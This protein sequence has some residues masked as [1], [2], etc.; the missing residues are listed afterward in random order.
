MPQ[1]EI[2][3]LRR[4]R[5][6]GYWLLVRGLLGL[7][8][9]VPVRVGRGFCVGLALVGLRLRPTDRRMAEAN[10]AR[11]FPELDT[12]GREGLLR[13]SARYLGR[14]LFDTLAAPRL[15]RHGSFV[16][17][18]EGRPPVGDV[19]ADLAAGG[20]GVFILTGHLGCWEL[21]GGYLAGQ[22]RL[23]GFDG[24]AVVTSTVH[25]PAV[26][27]LL[28]DRRRAMGMK[29]LPREQGAG[30]LIR[31]LKTGGVVAVLQ[32]QFTTTRNRDLPFFGEPA[33]TPEGLGL[34]ARRY[35]VPVLPVAIAAAP[36]G[37]G[38]VVR[39]LPVVRWHE[40]DPSDDPV[41]RFLTGCNRQL[42]TFIRRN[43]A[44]W[45]WFHK[46]WRDGDPDEKPATFPREKM[47]VD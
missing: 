3:V 21:L 29:V 40:A 45:V 19:L 42:E 46:R 38:H 10:L 26:D 22:L 6:R 37:P 16:S 14:N 15:L 23:R 11:A 44:Q 33:P 34:L 24:L 25:N 36:T 7:A 20:R 5:R 27:R 13:E 39:H 2:S 4:I 43:P 17:E 41:D 35:D 18:A 1:G 28:Q 32:D 31:W 47:N 12:T 30:P 9:W 8:R